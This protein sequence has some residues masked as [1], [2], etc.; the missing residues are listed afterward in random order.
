[1][2]VKRWNVELEGMSDF[3][4]SMD[5]VEAWL[6]GDII[7]RAPVRFTLHNAA[8]NEKRS[9]KLSQEQTRAKWFDAESVVDAFL[10]SIKDK[11]ILGDTFPVFMPNLGPG[12]FA[13]FFGCE[14]EFDELTSWTKPMS[15]S[16]KELSTIKPDKNNIY[17]QK[18]LE[19]TNCA[20]EKGRGK[21]MVGYTDLHPGLDCVAD[22]RGSQQLC[23]DMYDDPDGV[24]AAVRNTEKWFTEIYDEFDDL[25]K[26]NG[27]LSAT[28]MGIPSFGK[29]HVPSCDF[30]N[31]ISPEQFDRFC[32]PYAIQEC[33]HMTHN[34]WHLDGVGCMRHLDALLATEQIH[35]IQWVQGIGKDEPM[36]QWVPLIKKIVE[37]RKSVVLN[38][39][40]YE[41]D[42]FMDA[43][44]PD[45]L[46]I[47]VDAVSYQDQSDILR[48]FNKWK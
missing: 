16:L 46:F 17:Y 24:E 44:S 36:L 48:A 3:N 23:Y 2:N 45:R 5:R 47:C 35:A 1:M 37:N 4:R 27:H 18:I 29:M 12:V 38:I 13:A 11:P 19:L 6:N 9:S 42:D 32:L 33:A 7:D 14:L 21:C 30:S 40:H 10:S 34:I 25:L 43:I 26:Q 39:H 8:F 22:W 15:L 20:I 31:M 28:W 41:L